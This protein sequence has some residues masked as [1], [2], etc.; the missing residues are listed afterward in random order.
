MRVQR[1]VSAG[2][3]DSIRVL[4]YEIVHHKALFMATVVRLPAV[5]YS[6]TRGL[7]RRVSSIIPWLRA[8][9]FPGLSTLL[10]QPG[11]TDRLRPRAPSLLLSYRRVCKSFYFLA[12]S[13]SELVRYARP[14]LRLLL[15]PPRSL[16]S[17]APSW[18]LRGDGERT[19]S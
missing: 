15:S 5:I 18:I 19:C 14:D 12:N 13:I 4:V 17:A 1:A 10:A 2:P 6:T 7:S 11:R 8:C 9:V 3:I 16:M